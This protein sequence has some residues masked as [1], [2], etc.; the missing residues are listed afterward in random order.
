MHIVI[1]PLDVKFHEVLGI[2]KGIDQVGDKWW[3]IAVLFGDVIQSLIVLNWA[4][5]PIFLFDKEERGSHWR[6]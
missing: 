3:W 1:S 4:E 2:L 6:A 5:S